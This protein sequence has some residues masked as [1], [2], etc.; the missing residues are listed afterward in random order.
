M[1]EKKQKDLISASEPEL[2]AAQKTAK[3][4]KALGKT[5]KIVLMILLA[6]AIIIVA[7]TLAVDARHVRFYMSG[8]PEMDWECGREYIEPGIYAVTVGR[9]FGESSKRLHL[10]VEGEVDTTKLGSNQ[11][12]YTARYMLQDYSTSRTVNVVDTSPPEI[13]LSQTPG[14]TPSWL[15]GYVEEGFSAID[16]VDGD[17]SDKVLRSVEGDIIRYTVTDSSGNT[18]SLERKPGYSVS[19]PNIFLHGD[20]HM[21]I[22]AGPEYREPGYWAEDSLG[23]DLTSY[24]QVSG[25][26]K[27]YL[28]GE[29]S[30]SYSISNALG[31][32]V[33]VMRTVSVLPA[34]VPDTVQ[35]SEKTIYLTFDDGPGPYTEDL[36]DI[37]AKYN[38]K[39]TFFVTCANS[40]YEDSIGRAYSE[41]HSIGVH[42][43]SHNYRSIY[44]SEDAFFADFN[45]VQDMIYR[46]TGQY[47]DIC[48][49]PGGSSNT[50]S[51]FNPGIMSRLSCAVKDMGY[52]YFDWNVS[53]GDAGETTDSGQVAENIIAGCTGKQASVVLQ[54]DIKDYSVNAVEQV[55]IWGLENGYTFRP[56]D[57]SSPSAHHGISN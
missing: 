25:E 20:E 8:Q 3:P 29:Y 18:A 27:S 1:R 50:V 4:K 55:I 14:Y 23:N 15:D 54:H 53:S 33:S 31:E 39:V 44:A 32:T 5:G 42:T 52:Q 13:V 12:E 37:L 17:I 9:I 41:G 34:P 19:A 36:L 21:Q 45:L 51:N 16:N 10:R 11:L 46:Q 26:V 47:T 49:F 57:I 38:V 35:P 56:L 30:R 2:A 6:Y 48:R 24:V 28:A 40:K 7:V 43:A 22:Y